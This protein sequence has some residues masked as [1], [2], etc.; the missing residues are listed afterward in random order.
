MASPEQDNSC[1]CGMFLIA[2]TQEIT[3]KILR[4]DLDWNSTSLL[5]RVTP[6]TVYAIRF[7][8]QRII[9]SLAQQR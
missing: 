3:F 5:D 4:A 8:I 9:T 2:N 1:D 7:E 6:T